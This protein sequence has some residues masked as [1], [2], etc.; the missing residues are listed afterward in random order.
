MAY[1]D[2]T[3]FL[4]NW[5]LLLLA[6]GALFYFWGTMTYSRFTRDGIPH[7]KPLP[8]IGSMGPAIFKKQSPHDLIVEF[9]NKFK[10]RPYAVLFMFRQPFVFLID[11]ELIK[12]VGVKDFDYFTDHQ[13]IYME[14]KEKLWSKVLIVLKGEYKYIHLVKKI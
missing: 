6:A 9:Y 8:F 4:S 10:D 7:I 1:L 11:P 3:W 12:T 5:V 2:W 14:S 13:T